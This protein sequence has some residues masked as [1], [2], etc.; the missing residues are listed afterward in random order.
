MNIE[1]RSERPSDEDAIDVVNCRAFQSMSEANIVRLMRM[2]SPAFDPRYSI[3][4]WHGGDMVGHALFT[5][6]RI[7]LMGDTISALALGPIAVVPERQRQ[8]IGGEMIR[9][10]H[11]IGKREGLHLAF[12][13][14]HPSYYP[15]HGYRACYGFGKVKIDVDQLPEPTVKFD[16]LPVRAAD[17]PWLVE[18][19][20]AEWAD[21][22]FGWPWG[23][24]LSEWTIPCMNVVMWRTEDGT[25]AA[26]TM[27]NHGR[28]RC[29]LLLA[30]DPALA[31]EVIATIRP[32]TLEHHPSGW[33]ARHAL[34]PEWATAEAKPSKAAMACELQEG[35][36]DAY[37]QALESGN[38]LPGFTL[39]P[40]PFL[41]C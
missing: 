28:A 34:D 8:G 19:C 18:R 1:L 9:F 2:Y 17:V 30:D 24:S 32:A 6:A 35:V 12:L 10:G 21:V 5:P 23:T 39:F 38:R 31:R 40:L 29:K 26:Y 7:R 11:E 27:D 15:R 37:L 41:A 4:A 14:G 22:D 16:R 25:R 36:L 3:T 33:L 13:Y 20:A